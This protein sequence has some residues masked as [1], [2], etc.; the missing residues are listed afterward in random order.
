VSESP[1]DPARFGF[2]SSRADEVVLAMTLLTR[3]PMRPA[4]SG[5]SAAL[6]KAVWA[7]PLVGALVGG[8]GALLFT[9]ARA[10]N[11]PPDVAA[12]LTLAAMV[13]TTGC[14]HEDGL[15]DFWDG[16]GGGHTIDRKL[17]IMRDSRIGS[18]GAAA[19]I[20]S[21]GVRASLIASLDEAGYA[22]VGCILAGLLGRVG[23]AGIVATLPPA[24]V[25]GLAATAGTPPIE[26]TLGAMVIGLIATL[27][28][29]IVPG[30]SMLVAT[31]LTAALCYRLMM[32]QIKG[33]TGDGLGATEQKTE[34]AVLVALLASV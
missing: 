33:Y 11:M 9:M 25:D 12:W 21:F 27:S 22:A 5:D 3:I 13:L 28:F 19:L 20:L 23:I 1:A 32:K 8:I 15:A 17:E 2:W 18:Y 34:I 24:R 16:I 29:G 7:Y 4:R 10:L 30:I 31:A 14:F 6:A 26:S